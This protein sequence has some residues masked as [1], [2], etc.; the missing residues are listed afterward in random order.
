MRS[1]RCNG[2]ISPFLNQPIMK[3]QTT[4]D[5]ETNTGYL[6][7]LACL[8]LRLSS[9]QSPQWA[10][11]TCCYTNTYTMR[12]PI[13]SNTYSYSTAGR[14][15]FTHPPSHHSAEEIGF[16]TFARWQTYWIY[17]KSE[18]VSMH[19]N[20]QQKWWENIVWKAKNYFGDPSS[21]ADLNC[22]LP[23]FLTSEKGKK[24][25]HF[26]GAVVEKFHLRLTRDDMV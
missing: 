1:H 5:W 9:V 16:L 13:G 15:T 20:R 22:F 21:K 25:K 17:C 10:L 24:N 7:Q 12:L 6:Q 3:W 14:Y 4:L 23:V 11:G 26:S 18:I 8:K 2:Q 19:S